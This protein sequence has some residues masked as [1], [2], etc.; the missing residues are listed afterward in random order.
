MNNIPTDY[1]TSIT[2]KHG[3]PK[4]RA[5]CD[6]PLKMAKTIKLVLKFFLSKTYNQTGFDLGPN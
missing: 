6:L 5:S 3:Q 1:A 2:T 4:K